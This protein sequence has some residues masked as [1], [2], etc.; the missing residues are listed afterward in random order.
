M[1][2][3]YQIRADGEVL[4]DILHPEYAY[5]NG[6]LKKGVNIAGKLSFSLTPDNPV[7]SSVLPL[8][9]TITVLRHGKPIFAGRVLNVKKNLY[10]QR[11]V[12]CEGA[13]S[14]LYDV[15][16]P[17]T[18]FTNSNVS[19][20]VS[21]LLTKYNS[22]CSANR[23]FKVG[24]IDGDDVLTIS[25]K[26]DYDSVF[27]ILSEII[28]INGGYFVA[29]YD[30]NATPILNYYKNGIET[31]NEIRFGENLIDINEHIDTTKII[32][33]LY[34][35]GNN[36]ALPSPNYIENA[37]AV[38]AYGRIFGSVVFDDITSQRELITQAES[39]LKQNMLGEISINVKAVTLG[40]EA[41]EGNTV[42]IV[43]VPNGIDVR[44][45]VSEVVTDLN[46]EAAGYITVG[47]TRKTLTKT[48]ALEGK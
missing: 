48:L 31:S 36:V 23:V 15:V 35:T 37:D 24:T 14:W 25:A 29:T 13:L 17:P 47:T 40:W 5:Y 1:A 33:A 10:N 41:T 42:K 16:V 34:A 8:K 19:S 38:Q 43:S 6:K 32:T 26:S 9:T 18:S 7:I 28:K 20:I 45:I 21:S 3:K 2:S 22:L 44:A 46:N 12:I 4:A 30:K 11:E 39:Y 27:N